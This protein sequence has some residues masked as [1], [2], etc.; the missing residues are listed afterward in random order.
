MADAESIVLA[1]ATLR[2]TRNAAVHPQPGHSGSA[3]GEDFVRIGLMTDVPNQTVVRRIEDVMQGDR[4]LYR[5]KVGREMPAG[6][7]DRLE[8]KSAQL[9][10]QLQQLP[11]IELAHLRR[12][13]D[14]VE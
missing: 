12:I 5:A 3:T 11:T 10:G 8:Q 7:G 6:P 14:R 1:L 2:K 4:Q 9:V 13:A